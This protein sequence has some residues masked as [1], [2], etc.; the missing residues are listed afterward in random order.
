MTMTGTTSAFP[1]T[2]NA[3]GTRLPVA[4]GH[5]GEGGLKSS[6]QSPSV[7]PSIL[8]VDGRAQLLKGNLFGKKENPLQPVLLDRK[9]EPGHFRGQ[10]SKSRNVLWLPYLEEETKC[11]G[12]STRREQFWGT[13]IQKIEEELCKKIPSL[14]R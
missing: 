1:L 2:C 10:A 14:G 11:S 9:A 8:G 13:V 5:R 7:H 6:S 12:V 3:V 4:W